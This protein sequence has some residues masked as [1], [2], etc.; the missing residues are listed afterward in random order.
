MQANCRIFDP[1]SV[2]SPHWT[3]T[4]FKN[5]RC[6]NQLKISPLSLLSDKIHLIY[7]VPPDPMH[8]AYEGFFE[9]FI[10][11]MWS[12]IKTKKGGTLSN[13]QKVD[14]SQTMSIVNN[15]L[16]PVL[17]ARRPRL[18]F[19]LTHYKAAEY[20]CLLLYCS[21]VAFRNNVGDREYNLLKKIFCAVVILETR[22]LLQQEEFLVKAEQL[23]LEACTLGDEIF[24]KSFLT[25]KSHMMCH[26]VFLARRH[27]T[28]LSENSAFG[29][30]S[31]NINIGQNIKA[32]QNQFSCMTFISW[33]FTFQN[34]LMK[35]CV[36]FEILK[37]FFL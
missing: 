20:R 34:P 21:I 31:W 7:D 37:K 27:G 28:T 29:F 18:L 23:L 3:H 14:L 12:G 2:E 22:P 1:P 19:E 15:Q 24:G 32:C 4:D 6:A 33:I 5:F 25:V 13:K 11:A 17:F 10:V 8:V 30:E 26:F 36:L 16:K 35:K 9:R